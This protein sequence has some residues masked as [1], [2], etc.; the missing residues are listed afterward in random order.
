[1]TEFGRL[2]YEHDDDVKYEADF[3]SKGRYVIVFISVKVKWSW[4]SH[5]A[6]ERSI[7]GAST[8]PGEPKEAFEELSSKR[9]GHRERRIKNLWNID[10]SQME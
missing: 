3:D 1:M 7:V 6:D 4:L 5:L 8:M 10:S 9:G 2:L